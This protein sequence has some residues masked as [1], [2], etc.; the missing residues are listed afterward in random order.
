MDNVSRLCPHCGSAQFM[1]LKQYACIVQVDGLGLN[2]VPI[3]NIVKE[4]PKGQYE[5]KIFK[6][7]KCKHDIDVN[8]L[9]TGVKCKHCGKTCSPDE[10]DENG[11]CDTCNMII[12]NPA[13][14]NAS[15]A[16]LL[17]LLAKAYRK[18][19]SVSQKIEKK[20]EHATQIEQK[21][22]EENTA[23][24]DILNGVTPQDAIPQKRTRKK[25]TRKN[26]APQE[27]QETTQES[28]EADGHV[29]YVPDI[30]AESVVQEN[31]DSQVQ[32]PTQPENIPINTEEAQ[33]AIASE[34]DAPFPDIPTPSIPDMPTDAQ[35]FTNAEPPAP[36]GFNMFDASDDDE[37][38]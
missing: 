12:N 38:F 21:L 29:V 34:Q 10:I 2:D 35:Q 19:S 25:A 17:K 32:P 26:P 14:A 6:C 27:N 4:G 30:P 15:A 31:N 24:D 20:V 13:L 37:P 1:A 22:N 16:D 8:D 33:A 18:N 3:I 11:I 28:N 7:L 36:S 9:I 5:V 23:A